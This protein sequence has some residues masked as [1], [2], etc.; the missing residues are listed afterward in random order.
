LFTVGNWMIRV[1]HSIYQWR[2]KICV[3]LWIA[4][5]LENQFLNSSVQVLDAISNGKFLRN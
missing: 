2:E 3:K 5:S 1:R 4:Y